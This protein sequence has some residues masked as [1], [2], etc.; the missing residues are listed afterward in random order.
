MAGRLVTVRLIGLTGKIGAGKSS[1]AAMLAGHGAV[2]IDADCF[3]AS[4]LERQG[5]AFGPTVRR[6]GPSI[7]DATGAID[8]SALARMVFAEP[9][10]RRDLEA[11]VHPIVAAGI[12]ARLA[13]EAPG[14]RVVVLDIPLLA[15]TRADLTYPFSGTLVVDASAE[16]V[17]DRLERERGMRRAEAEARLSA[18]A[19]EQ[20]R[21]ALADFIILNI[22]SLAELEEMV[23]RAWQWVLSLPP[24][25]TG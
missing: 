10:A 11:I 22:G 15:E 24:G 23:A 1:V 5:A 9:S 6:F 20:E 8:R 17:L 13:A 18:Q 25:E 21:N 3:A 16:V 14:D 19:S 2:V 4:S 12:T 7:L